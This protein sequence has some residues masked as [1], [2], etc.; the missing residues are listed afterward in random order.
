MERFL[1]DLRWAART[2]AKSPGFAAAAVLS[3]ALGIGA[4]SAIFSLLNAVVLRPLPVADPQELV[5]LS[6]VP[7]LWETNPDNPTSFFS[8]PQLEH[9]RTQSK[10]VT[11]IFASTG[12]GRMNVAFRGTSG[13]AQGEASTANF[14]AVLGVAPQ[15][16]R[17][18][19]DEEDVAD[20]SVA[21]ISDRYWRTRFGADP[22][23]VGGAVTINQLPFTVI[24]IAPREFTGTSVGNGPDVWTPLHALDR[25]R[26][27]HKRWIEPFTSWLAIAGRVR[28]GVSREQAQAEL[29]VLHR[30]LLVE[31]LATSEMRAWPKL[32]RFV[33]ESH[34]VLQPAANGLSSGLRDRYA[35]PLK[36][37]MAVAG[38]VLLAACANVANLLLAR[39]SH[40]RREIAVRLALGARRG[41]LVRQLL[42]ESILLAAMSGAVAVAIAWWGSAAL[43]RMISTGDVPMPLDVHPDWRVFGFTTAVSMVTGILFGL[44]PAV[45]GTRVDPAQAMKEGTRH[46]GGQAHALDRALVAVQ[47]ALSVVLVAGAG[48]FVRTLEKLRSV[49]LG[50]DR[51]SVLMFSVDAKLAGYGADRAG[52]LYREILDRL[53]VL[54][55]VQSAGVSIMRPVDDQFYLV[56]Q[57]SEVDGRALRPGDSFQ[58]A[59]NAISPGYFATVRTPILAGR[60]FDFRD[61]ETAPKVAIV[62]ES[63]ARRVFAGESPLGHRLAGATIVG[64]VKDARYNGARDQPRPVLY[65]PLFQHGRDQEYRWGYVSFELRNR[66]RAGL[67]EEVRREVAAVDHNLPIFRIRTLEAQTEQSLLRERLLATLGSFF[68]A[69]A[70]LLACVGLY[71]LMAY[72]VARRTGEIAIRLALGARRGDVLWLV[73]RETLGLALVGTAAGVPLALWAARYAKSLLFGI[74]PS[75]PLTIALTVAVLTAVATLAGYLPARRALR[76]D[77]MS[78]L[79]C[80]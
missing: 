20:A 73:L 24:G 58:V 30:Q 44:A 34:L 60:D 4:N 37:L 49:E 32:Q 57:V 21:V 76:V 72:A 5:Q 43:V 65:H 36:L 9:F 54:A 18:F 15:Q 75:D 25:I 23:I 3:L 26:P 78:A 77:P 11:G 61:N 50:Y 22:S 13:L 16:G 47:V 71:G 46:S 62:N 35:L 59:W 51:A 74:S 39:G 64:V 12:L 7:G 38:M 28:P 80:E 70:L 45:R 56:D 41:R 42:T 27:F 10:T 79:R 55:D 68:G 1:Q 31:Q 19:R 33:R 17:F 40:R 6:Y 29:D 69:L 67:L 53:R 48:L 66:G 14:F 52:A 2:L 8:Y 63:L